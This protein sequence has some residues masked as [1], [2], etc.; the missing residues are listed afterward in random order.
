LR[1][2]EQYALPWANISW[3][4]HQAK[5]DAAIVEGRK[6][7]TKTTSSERMIGLLPMAYKALQ[8]QKIINRPEWSEY[9]FVN[10]VTKRHYRHNDETGERLKTL[11]KKAG[12]RYRNQYQTRHSYAS[13]LLSG[14]ENIYYV[15]N[16]L[17]HKNIEMVMR[18]YGHYIE[19]GR[20]KLT[21]EVISKLW[22]PV[23]FLAF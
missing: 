22:K 9:V 19:Q 21:L 11:C 6:K 20:E 15:A 18:V 4:D 2:S 12:V 8:D 3:K 7:E 17:G 5:I 23:N 1:T 10:P 14:G 13:N 16:Q